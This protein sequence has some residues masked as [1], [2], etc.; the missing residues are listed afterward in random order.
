MMIDALLPFYRLTLAFDVISVIPW[1]VG[2][3]TM[4][5]RYVECARDPAVAP[6]LHWFRENVRRRMPGGEGGSERTK[7]NG[8]ADSELSYT[9]VQ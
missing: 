2:M 1:M 3:L 5:R 4:P 9:S 8:R 6:R 7:Y